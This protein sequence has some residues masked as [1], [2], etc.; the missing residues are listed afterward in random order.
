MGGKEV[1]NGQWLKVEDAHLLVIKNATCKGTNCSDFQSNWAH[2]TRCSPQGSR[3]RSMATHGF[4]NTWSAP[5]L[6]DGPKGSK[7]VPWLLPLY[8]PWSGSFQHFTRDYAPKLALVPEGVLRDPRLHVLVERSSNAIVNGILEAF[9]ISR[10]RQLSPQEVHTVTAERVYI[11]A[12][13]AYDNQRY[14]YEL[15]RRRLGVRYKSPPARRT[16]MY[17]SRHGASSRR[18]SNEDSLLLRLTNWIALRG[19]NERLVTFSRASTLNS[20]VKS[21]SDVKLFIGAHGGGMYNTFLLP[22]N[23]AIIEFAPLENTYHPICRSGSVLSHWY[24]M[25][26]WPNMGHRTTSGPID[27][28]LLQVFFERALQHLDDMHLNTSPAR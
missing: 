27:I 8:G 16:I 20:T 23:T 19:R 28:D 17:F 9:G 12:A 11:P 24:W 21:L 3:R 10:D 1:E 18:I 4:C 22:A 25:F 5:S 7:H 15:Y 14:L 6:M 26:P 13:P 2:A